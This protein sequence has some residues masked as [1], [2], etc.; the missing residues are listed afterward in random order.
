MEKKSE[1]RL[2][3]FKGFSANVDDDDDDDDDDDKRVLTM[4]LPIKVH[5]VIQH[6]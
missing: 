5:T 2:R 1:R 3:P 6:E 4:W